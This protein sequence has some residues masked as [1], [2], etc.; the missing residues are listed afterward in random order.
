M[1]NIGKPV[2]LLA[3]LAALG[4]GGPVAVTA[5]ASDSAPTPVTTTGATGEQDGANDDL[6]TQ[7]DD[8]NN[9]ENQQGD[10][11]QDGDNN[12]LAAQVET[13]NQDEGQ[14]GEN[15]DDEKTT[16]APTGTTGPNGAIGS[17]GDSHGN[18]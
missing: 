6:A 3:A 8:A 4:V 13:G 18:D 5:F 9:D 15:G 17:N 10:D 14:Q 7:V 1:K 11:E 12:D 2:L 16:T